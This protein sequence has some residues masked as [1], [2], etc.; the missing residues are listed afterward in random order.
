MD[1]L[2]HK[3]IFLHTSNLVDYFFSQP[4]SCFSKDLPFH[5]SESFVPNEQCVEDSSTS[6][7]TVSNYTE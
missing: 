3:Y 4:S 6:E 1:I 2:T 5:S 7:S